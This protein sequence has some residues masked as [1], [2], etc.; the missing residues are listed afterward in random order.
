MYVGAKYIRTESAAFHV[1]GILM[2]RHVRATAVWVVVPEDRP[3]LYA[4]AIAY[5]PSQT[6]VAATRT[7]H[8]L[9]LLASVTG[10]GLVTDV[11]VPEMACRR[12][13]CRR[14]CR[15]RG[16]HAGRG[17]NRGQEHR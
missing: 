1:D 13:S 7:R 17:E 5:S 6:F 15:D 16:R 4:A 11:L 12:H 14:H 3:V 9:K 10:G 8:T 2:P